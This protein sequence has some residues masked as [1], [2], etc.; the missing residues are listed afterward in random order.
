M[1]HSNQLFRRA[2][3]QCEYFRDCQVAE[4][5]V[6]R[7]SGVLVGEQPEEEEQVA[8]P[9]AL[10]FQMGLRGA[11]LPEQTGPIV[12]EHGI[13]VTQVARAQA[14][15]AGLAHMVPQPE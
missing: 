7:L 12:K 13:V 15:T 8:D 4:N 1:F 10:V 3:C 14:P 11:A 9:D 5:S 6:M 2:I